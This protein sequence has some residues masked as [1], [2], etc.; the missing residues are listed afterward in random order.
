MNIQ[1]GSSIVVSDPGTPCLS[2]TRCPSCQKY[3]VQIELAKQDEPL[4]QW[5]VIPKVMGRRAIH[6]SVPPELVADFEEAVLTLQ[7]SP[8]SSATLSRRCLQTLFVLQ[9]AKKRDLVDQLAEIYPSLPSY[10]QSF[11]DNVRKLGNL[12]A[13]AKQSIATG[14][15]VTVEP[16]EAEWMLELLEELFDHY[17][18]KPAEAQARQALLT[19]KFADAQRLKNT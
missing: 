10:I 18:A 1:E 12:A 19:A 7:D 15:I 11:V 16:G 6:G 5:L 2:F 4:R 3:I 17:Y 9:G 8:K 14:A 13:H